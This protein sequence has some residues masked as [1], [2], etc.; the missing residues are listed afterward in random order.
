MTFASHTYIKYVVFM[1]RLLKLYKR[2]LAA[3]ELLAFYW[4]CSFQLVVGFLLFFFVSKRRM[5][6]A[7]RLVGRFTDK[8]KRLVMAF[9]KMSFTQK[10]WIVCSRRQQQ[11]QQHKRGR[12]AIKL[13]KETLLCCILYGWHCGYSDW[14][15]SELLN[16]VIRLII[17]LTL[18]R[19]RH[20]IICL[21]ISKTTWASGF[22]I[23]RTR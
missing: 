6:R 2:R 1:Y 14:I 12:I 8:H 19:R 11:Q 22:K 17:G 23:Y 21:N 16:L 5:S 18:L 20:K 4:A 3:F 10:S 7:I 13:F 9:F 15:I